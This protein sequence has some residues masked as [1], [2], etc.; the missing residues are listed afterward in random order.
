MALT[1]PVSPGEE[2]STESDTLAAG[3]KAICSF[4]TKA[5]VD[6]VLSWAIGNTPR[7]RHTRPWVRLGVDVEHHRGQPA[8]A[9]YMRALTVLDRGLH[10]T[11][12]F[13]VVAVLDAIDNEGYTALARAFAFE[14]VDRTALAPATGGFATWLES[15]ED[16]EALAAADRFY[17]RFASFLSAT[18]TARAWGHDWHQWPLW[19]S[20]DSPQTHA[21]RLQVLA[22]QDIAWFV[23]REALEDPRYEPQA[24]AMWLSIVRTDSDDSR[25]RA[26]LHLMINEGNPNRAVELALDVIGYELPDRWV[27]GDVLRYLYTQRRGQDAR[28]RITAAL[29]NA[30]ITPTHRTALERLLAVSDELEGKN[31][32]EPISP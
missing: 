19:P 32:A 14:G 24:T 10:E 22:H 6:A 30:A 20:R 3:A 9:N 26:L 1:T 23:I 11:A 29:A 25:R 15:Q 7:M 21:L 16:P 31:P 18:R 17:E 27:G 4:G 12:R 28:A 8:A 13:D 2:T 5:D